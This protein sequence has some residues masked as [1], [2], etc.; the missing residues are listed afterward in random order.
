[1]D[2]DGSNVQ[3]L[4]RGMSA[5]AAEWSPDGTKIAFDSDHQ[6]NFEIYVMNTDG[7][8]VRRLTHDDKVDA[9]P[10]GSPDGR[11]IV[12]HSTRHEGS[13]G[14]PEQRRNSEILVMDMDGSHV[15]RLTSNE[16]CDAHPAW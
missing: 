3:Q 9:R 13:P 5:G 11:R 1:M 8:H 7:S 14:G 15:R 6:G 12:F 10:A 2:A 16:E 4:T